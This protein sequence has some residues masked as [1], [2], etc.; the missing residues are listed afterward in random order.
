MRH[1]RLKIQT[2]SNKYSIYIGTNLS[3]KIKTIL[4]NE[5]I[6]FNK[7]LIIYDSKIKLKEISKI[8]LKL[9]KKNVFV[10][11]FVSNEKSKSF[12]TVNKIISNLFLLHFT[13]NYL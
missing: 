12:K 5:K 10:Y 3:N 2:S 8:K 4:D 1:N 11:K 6:F 7:V 13:F 9:K